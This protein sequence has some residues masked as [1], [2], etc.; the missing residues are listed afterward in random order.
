M[1]TLFLT[2]LSVFFVFGMLAGA[3]LTLACLAFR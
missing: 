1:K 3:L 2:R